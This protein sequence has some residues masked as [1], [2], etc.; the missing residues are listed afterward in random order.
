MNVDVGTGQNPERLWRSEAQHIKGEKPREAPGRLR[1]D[2][3]LHPWE[4]PPYL[5]V[6]MA[7]ET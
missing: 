7:T 3:A 2:P 4:V 5:Q 1:A 6:C